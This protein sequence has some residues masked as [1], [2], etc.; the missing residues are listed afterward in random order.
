MIE[1]KYIR[2]E[3][4]DAESLVWLLPHAWEA[5]I[6]WQLNSDKMLYI[7]YFYIEESYI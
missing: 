5:W 2:N 7:Q 4:V 3:Y 1:I 6:Q